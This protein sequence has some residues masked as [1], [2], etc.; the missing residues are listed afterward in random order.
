[1]TWLV[2]LVAAGGVAGITR[3]RPGSRDD[4]LVA[5]LLLLLMAWLAASTVSASEWVRH[6][7]VLEP[8]ALVAIVVTLAIARHAPRGTTYWLAIEVAGVVAVY[9][10]TAPTPWLL[11]GAFESWV[12]A[13]R[14]DLDVAILVCLCGAVWLATAWTVFWV[15]VRRSLLWALLPGALVLAVEV[16][17]DPGES[18]L[19]TRVLT[20]VALA[21]AL[22]MTLNLARLQRRWGSRAEDVTLHTAVAGGRALVAALVVAVV[23]PPLTSVD[24]SGRFFRTET[25]PA[26]A[27]TSGRGAGPG[28]GSGP[29]GTPQ[30]IGYSAE[31]VPGA[32]L[33]RGNQ[34]VLQTVDDW[35]GTHYWRGIDLYSVTDGAWQLG[36]ASAGGATNRLPA[37]LAAQPQ[38][39]L[40]RTVVHAQVKITGNPVGPVFWPGE[41]GTID[42]PL[43]TVRPV[44]GGAVTNLLATAF[45]LNA[46]GVGTTYSETGTLSTAS[47]D[48]LR[49]ASGADPGWVTALT[50]G[51][52]ETGRIDPRIHSLAQRLTATA[53]NR[54][55]QAKAVE[56]YLRGLTYRL[57]VATPP[58]NVDPVTFFL[59]QT[60][61]GY[62][63]YFASSMGEMLRSLG[64]PVRLVNGYGPG[65][66]S[67]AQEQAG[68]LERHSIYNI[69]ASD[70]HTWVE[71]YFPQYGWI[72]FEPTPDPL[73]PPIPR[74]NA[75]P[76]TQP[77]TV[78][79]VP[80]K[81]PAP[82]APP[83]PLAW[84]WVAAPIAVGVVGI[85]WLLSL[86]VLGSLR[87]RDYGAAWRRLT[88]L[89][90]RLRLDASPADTPIELGR[91]L[92]AALP[93]LEADIETLAEGYSRRCYGL[94]GH[95][96]PGAGEAWQ[97]VRARVPWLLLFGRG[98]ARATRL[99]AA[100]LPGVFA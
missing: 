61:T 88:W 39:D 35:S 80:G 82:H 98:H 5:Y 84:E 40:A 33:K 37:S 67:P 6:T 15:A 58:K 76:S 48:Q 70:A 41:P 18:S 38:G 81:V 47:E 93:E 89:A 32:T 24:I 87:L 22:G 1:M 17:N 71:V 8:L 74:G 66:L 12:L 30:Q 75:Q 91:R 44:A 9:L 73:Y 29:A 34:P 100:V 64:I 16:I 97:R 14:H 2:A 79:V 28:S 57:E 86:L 56:T 68:V 96:Q 11:P 27:G 7:D 94:E 54:Y 45:A 26:E 20:W 21:I 23:L 95:E 92:A 59:F 53:T 78:P 85:L 10:M 63:E 19:G 77:Q 3:L 42:H 52:G 25:H 31:V 99:A 72:P 50:S 83:A 4:G 13:V 36:P 49:A 51:P 62:C 55:D 60:K 69:V 43:L 90:R 65:T 46:Q